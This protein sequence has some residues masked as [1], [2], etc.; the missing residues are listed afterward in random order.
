MA[1][2]RFG[3]LSTAGIGEKRVIP[4]IHR[5]HNAE[6]VA[7]ASRDLERARAFADEHD[8]PTAYGT[9]E[10]LL[11]ADDVDAIYNP[12]PNNLHAEWA[13]KSARA[14]KPMLCEKPLALNAAQG[15]QMV[16]AFAERGL[17]F[18]EAFM[19][20]F[21]PQTVRV[22]ELIAQGAIGEPHSVRATFTFTVKDADNIRLSAALG[23]GALADVGYYCVGAIRHIAG[24][25]PVSV[26]GE[27]VMASDVDVSFS[28]VLRFESGLLGYFEGG[29]RSFR[30]HSYTVLGSTGK[31]EVAEAFV[32]LPLAQTQIKLWR[33][34]AET[35]EI[36][37]IPESDQYQ[38]MV[39]DFADALL[40]GS[41]PRFDPQDAV[42]Q[43]QVLDALK[44]NAGIVKF[45]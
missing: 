37:T 26:R 22:H 19:Y 33:D 39:E 31:I 45:A 41:P 27:A 30:E 40:T 36:I 28:G 18:A 17:L 11:A 8:I 10:A 2:I 21:H 29:L 6:V 5:A 34:S 44:A 12:L 13:I 3:I 20:R 15:Q 24:A 32:P 38:I 35:P 43:M 7:V 1:K 42:R 14:G 16:D 23:G 4:A 9:Y 25:E